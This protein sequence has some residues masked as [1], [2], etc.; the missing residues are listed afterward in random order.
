MRVT[1]S[2]AM[3]RKLWFHSVRKTGHFQNEHSYLLLK[4]CTVGSI[5]LKIQSFLVVQMLQVMRII[6]S[7]KKDTWSFSL[8]SLKMPRRGLVV[9][10]PAP[11]DAQQAF[12][13]LHRR[14]RD[15]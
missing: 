4:F 9:N 2:E 12:A 6:I 14:N 1:G 11:M 5:S 13:K 10:T 7:I 3:L 15:A 8:I